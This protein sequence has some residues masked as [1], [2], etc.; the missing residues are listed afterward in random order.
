MISYRENSPSARRAAVSSGTG[1]STSTAGCGFRSI[2]PISCS[3]CVTAGFVSSASST[4]TC[5]RRPPCSSSSTSC[6][7]DAMAAAR[8]SSP[9]VRAN[10]RMESRSMRELNANSAT[11]AE[12]RGSL[13][14]S[15][16]FCPAASGRSCSNTAMSAH[17]RSTEVM[18]YRGGM[19]RLHGVF[20]QETGQH[21][22]ALLLY[23]T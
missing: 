22:R 1:T 5:G 9:W 20:V 14:A 10:S 16:C 6:P 13:S 4:S 19:R 3:T 11:T 12:V 2:L 7:V 8:T 15:L 17:L 21:P 23:L 18:Q